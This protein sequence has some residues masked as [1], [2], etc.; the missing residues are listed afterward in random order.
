MHNE[1]GDLEIDIRFG[2]RNFAVGIG[3]DCAGIVASVPGNDPDPQGRFNGI[4]RIA[5]SLGSQQYASLSESDIEE[6]LFGDR[7]VKRVA[8]RIAIPSVGRMALTDL[9]CRG[10][11]VERAAREVFPY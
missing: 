4:D 5:C 9:R 6:K 1:A 2:Q 3:A 8:S 7:E 11:D 10:E